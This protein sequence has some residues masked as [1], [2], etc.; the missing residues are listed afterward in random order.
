MVL[1]F[2]TMKA[3]IFDTH[4][5]VYS[6]VKSYIWNSW[7]IFYNFE[8]T[9]NLSHIVNVFLWIYFRNWQVIFCSLFCTF[10]IVSLHLSSQQNEERSRIEF[11]S[12]SACV[13]VWVCVCVCVFV[14]FKRKRDR[15][16]SFFSLTKSWAFFLSLERE[17]IYTQV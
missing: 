16:I 4:G 13:R 9:N 8:M 1:I 12:E 7:M 5:S 2:L 3:T 14:C 6:F 15:P 10:K 17:N 11:L